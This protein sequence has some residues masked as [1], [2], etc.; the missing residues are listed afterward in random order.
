M[1][2]GIKFSSVTISLRGVPK[3]YDAMKITE[4]VVGF[5]LTPLFLLTAKTDPGI[6]TTPHH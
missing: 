5:L 2:R 6:H 4:G 3:V 1:K